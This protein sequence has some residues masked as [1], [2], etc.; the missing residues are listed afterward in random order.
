MSAVDKLHKLYSS[1]TSP[2]VWAR[3][4]GVEVLNELDVLKAGIMGAAGGQS[5]SGARGGRRPSFFWET[6]ASG[7]E[8]LA[9]G[10]RVAGAVGDGLRS[11][12]GGILQRLTKVVSGPGRE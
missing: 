4:T 2:V 10:T 9:G 8:A 7:V 12:A 1:T 3:S 11:T 5:E 6:I